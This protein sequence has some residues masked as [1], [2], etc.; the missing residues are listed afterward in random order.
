MVAIWRHV[1]NMPRVCLV[2]PLIGCLTY[3]ILDHSWPHTITFLDAFPHIL[4][5]IIDLSAQRSKGKDHNTLRGS[6]VSSLNKVKLW[7]II[8]IYFI[9]TR[10]AGERWPFHGIVESDIPFSRVYSVIIVY[11]LQS[12]VM[13]IVTFKFI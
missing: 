12:E 11:V 5:E 2:C 7:S 1:A 6:H 3:L 10:A 4:Y 8:H 13:H 9:H